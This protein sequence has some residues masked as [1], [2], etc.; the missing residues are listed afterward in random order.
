MEPIR[1]ILSSLHRFDCFFLRPVREYQSRDGC[2][3]VFVFWRVPWSWGFYLRY[4]LKM[5]LELKVRCIAGAIVRVRV[6]GVI[7]DITIEDSSITR[8]VVITTDIREVRI[9]GVRVRVPI[10]GKNEAHTP[11]PNCVFRH[12]IIIRDPRSGSLVQHCVLDI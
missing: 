2:I 11:I 7:V 6:R 4:T 12:S 8:I 3:A 5:R 10:V 1:F 9:R